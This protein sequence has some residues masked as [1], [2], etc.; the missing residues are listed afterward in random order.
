MIARSLMQVVAQEANRLKIRPQDVFKA[1]PY[2]GTNTNQTIVTGLDM[3]VNGS[4]V[5]ASPRYGVYDQFWASAGVDLSPNT[6][7]ANFYSGYYGPRV[8]A[9][10][11]TL[12]A[13]APHNESGTSHM[14][15]SF[16]KQIGFFTRVQWTG[17]GAANRAIPHDLGREVGFVAIKRTDTTS[18]WPVWHR[19]LPVGHDLHISAAASVS[20]NAAF[21]SAPDANNLY[22]GSGSEVNASGGSYT[23]WI[24][25]HNPSLIHCGSAVVDG[26]GN[27]TV[28]LGWEPQFV[29]M[30]ANLAS[31]PYNTVDT[32]RGWGT[33]S[34]KTIRLNE[35]GT[36]YS[37]ASG[38]TKTSTGFTIA[39]LAAGTHLFVAIRKETT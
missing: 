4:L 18:N 17:N 23:A 10:G 16:K 3:T 36:E 31:S 1:T 20:S 5:W 6:N 37:T 8:A 15:W 7:E 32:A 21:F 11:F 27:A 29:M 2:T 35:G 34:P 12:A 25:A 38:M 22:L 24:W 19:G 33:G 14:S 28:E 26:S 30:K 9:T 13:G 39:G